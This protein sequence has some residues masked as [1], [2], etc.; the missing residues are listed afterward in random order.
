MTQPKSQTKYLRFAELAV[1][2]GISV[3]MLTRLYQERRIPGIK[4]GYR[5]LVFELERV[6]EA[7]RAF[8]VKAEVSRN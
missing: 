6:Q 7:L 2:T 1:L 5:T 4:L 8:E 3:S